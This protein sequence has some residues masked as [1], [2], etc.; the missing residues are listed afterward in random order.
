MVWRRAVGAGAFLWPP[1]PGLGSRNIASRQP[2]V[3]LLPPTRSPV[4]VVHWE[5][6]AAHWPLWSAPIP[7]GVTGVTVISA[8]VSAVAA[9]V[10]DVAH[11]PV[12]P[13]V[14]LPRLGLSV[15]QRCRPITRSAL[16]S[17]VLQTSV[18]LLRRLSS[19]PADDA[20]QPQLTLAGAGA[21]SGK[22]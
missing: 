16:T 21:S 1:P 8:M 19:S 5:T 9:A 15:Y 13:L 2:P 22:C 12:L 4:A 7:L 18:A 3:G 10:V 14:V 17:S 6:R 20:S 11:K